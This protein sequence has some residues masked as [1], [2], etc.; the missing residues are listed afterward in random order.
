MDS[1]TGS[2]IALWNGQSMRDSIFGGH[3]Q[4]CHSIVK[5]QEYSYVVR[6]KNESPSMP[7]IT[8]L[9]DSKDA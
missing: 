7:F 3:A 1:A 5:R 9:S 4:E 2:D 6:L 8:A